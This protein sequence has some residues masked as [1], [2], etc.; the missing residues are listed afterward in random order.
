MVNF[1]HGHVHPPSPDSPD[2]SSALVC[3]SGLQVGLAKTGARRANLTTH[4][5][6]PSMSA[7]PTSLQNHCLLHISGTSIRRHSYKIFPSVW[8]L[9]P[10]HRQ[11]RLHCRLDLPGPSR[12]VCMRSMRSGNRI[13]VS[14]PSICGSWLHTK[15]CIRRRCLRP[16]LASLQ[17][18]VVCVRGLVGCSSPR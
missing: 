3:L 9:P 12:P 8:A 2:I 6:W 13:K 11:Y 15:R 4:L 17:Y 1:V 16:P 10:W 5:R 7:L 14:C 18:V